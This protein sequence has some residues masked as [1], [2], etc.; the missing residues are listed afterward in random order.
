MQKIH[1]QKR[2]EIVL[3]YL[4]N[5]Y[6]FSKFINLILKLIFNYRLINL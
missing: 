5:D 1:F 3:V 4:I 6:N 2:I